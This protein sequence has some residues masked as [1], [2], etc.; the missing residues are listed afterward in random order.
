MQIPRIVASATALVLPLA[1]VTGCGTTQ[2]ASD[3]DSR[4]VA[5]PPAADGGDDLPDGI[6]PAGYD[7]RFRATLTVLE[8]PDHGP[9]LCSAV[10]RSY[11]PQC[12]GPDVEGWNW[13]AVRA[14]TVN[15]TTW[16]H[17]TV[18][19]RFADGVFTLTE[20]P[21]SPDDATDEPAADDET[22]VA[23]CPE[24]AGG[25]VPPDPERA[26]YAAKEQTES[27]RCIRL[28]LVVML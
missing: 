6:V 8:S 18:T 17:Y 5:A 26:T 28:S 10:L 24:P 4:A 27:G 14:E 19:G 21:T 16:G 3:D 12:S 11:P 7:G 22:P 25:W 2:R 23:A 1:V 9:Q 20:P 15:G 13:D